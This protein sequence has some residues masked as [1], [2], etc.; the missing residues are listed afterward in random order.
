MAD[1]N[2]IAKVTVSMDVQQAERQ[3]QVLNDKARDLKK[4]IKEIQKLKVLG[5]ATPEQLTQLR[6]MRT[7]LRQVRKDSKELSVQLG[8]VSKVLNNLSS[9]P[10]KAIR[11]AI[12]TT[13]AQMERLDRSTEQYAKKQKELAVLRAELDKINSSANKASS[14]LSQIGQTMKRLASY[15]L[16]YAGFNELV[17]GIQRLISVNAELSDQYADISK[18]TGL[19]GNA[20]RGLAEDIRNIDTRTSVE[21]LNNLAY[22]AGKLG[23]QGREN[24]LEFVK[25]G[26]QINV[27]LGEELGE[28]AIKNIAKL[29]D[30]LGITK[31]LG[32]ERS[33]LA[34]GSAINELGQTSTANEGYLVDFAQRMGGI[35]KQAGLTIQQILALGSAADQ[36]GQN[37]EV[38]ATALNKVVTT[39][40]SQTDQVAKAIGVT[41]EELSA[42]LNE[43]TWNG[44]MLVFE[45]LAGKGGLAAIAPLMGELGSDGARLNAVVSSLTSNLDVMNTALATSNKAFAEAT[46]LTAETMKRE[47]SLMGIWQRAMKNVTKIFQDSKINDQLKDIAVYIY[48]VTGE[49]DEFGNRIGGAIS[50]FASFT[51]LL[52]QFVNFLIRNIDSIAVFAASF[53]TLKSAIIGAQLATK[54]YGVVL[55]ALNVSHTAARTIILLWNSAVALLSGNLTRATA[56]FKLFRA[57]I[58]TIPFGAAVTAAAALGTAIYTIYRRSTEAAREYKRF[59]TELNENIAAEQ[60]QAEY[61]FSVAQKTAAGTEERRKAIADINAAYG[62]YLPNLIQ[63]TASQNDLAEALKTVNSELQNSIALKMKQ[64]EIQTTTRQSLTSQMNYIDQMNAASKTT[65]EMNSRMIERINELLNVYIGKGKSVGELMTII[66]EDLLNTFGSAGKQGGEYWEAMYGYIQETITQRKKLAEI[67]T[68]YAPWSPKEKEKTNVLPEV[69]VTATGGSAAGDATQ[70]AIKER[71]QQEQAAIDLWLQHKKNALSE[72]RLAEQDA[73]SESYISQEEYN[74]AIEGLEMEAMRKRLAILGLEPNEVAKI[75]GQILDIRRKFME[76]T[77]AAQKKWADEYDK[78]QTQL[79]IRTEDK[80]KQNLARINVLYDTLIQK[81]REGVE[82]NYK[83]QEQITEDIRMF[84][85]QRQKVLNNYYANKDLDHLDEEEAKEAANLRESFI[86]RE[87]DYEEYQRQLNEM[88]LQYAEV[89]T[90]ITDVEESKKAELVRRYHEQRFKSAKQSYDKEKKLQQQYATVIQSSLEGIGGAFAQL[91]SGSENSMEQMRDAIVDTLFDTL[92]QMVDI[93]LTELGITATASIAQGTMKEIGSKGLLGIATG[94][95]ISGI[96]YGLL[97]VAKSAIKSALKG[98]GGNSN[99]NPSGQR[100]VKTSGFAVGGSTG[101][102]PVYEVAGVV[103]RGEYVVPK[104]QMQDPISFNYVRALET[105]RQT[106]SQ[107]NILSVRRSGYAEGGMVQTSIQAGTAPANDPQ[108]LTLMHSMYNLLSSLQRDGVKT[109]FSVSRLEQTQTQ[110]NASRLRGSLKK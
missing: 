61:L 16:V 24:I 95:A 94:A 80:D 2:R 10:V 99:A 30:V 74:R 81:A 33:L 96:V 70:K 52:A 92:T 34:T 91:A 100:V 71:I 98:K 106:R 44:L 13:T 4:D 69:V 9:A 14:G 1:N 43:S 67:D 5:I 29:N 19:E 101:D 11:D 12:K 64:E 76:Q 42:A 93:W 85:E 90:Q 104:W 32:V 50:I 26:N 40:V 22:T 7:A 75:E 60:S 3:L 47:E 39:L 54:A 20:L 65:D 73:N 48:Q 38:S 36:M 56:A 77:E 55:T 53:I 58:A 31:Q 66:S 35:A 57:A 62:Q 109:V 59:K 15:V 83:S 105:I 103:H 88:E 6:D 63:E 97:A 68:R 108:M 41:Y 45:K 84:E 72:A 82:A 51:K 79:G 89:R 49:F 25:A 23:I 46:S 86:N 37:V 107:E 28:D 27:A 102:G 87:M 18:T 110:L 78:L 21:Q 17:N 8:D